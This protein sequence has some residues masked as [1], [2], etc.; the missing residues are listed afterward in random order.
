MPLI[1]DAT[2]EAS[3]G[4]VHQGT[5]NQQGSN[6]LQAPKQASALYIPS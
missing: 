5:E 4:V 2:A 1:S 3:W 6:R